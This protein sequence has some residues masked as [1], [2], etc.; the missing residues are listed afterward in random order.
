VFSGC[1]SKFGCFSQKVSSALELVGNMG[2]G[3]REI[4]CC[5]LQKIAYTGIP[6]DIQVVDPL[7]SD[8]KG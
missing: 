6:K 4:T 5:D 3:S 8:W 2:F 1:D 7:G